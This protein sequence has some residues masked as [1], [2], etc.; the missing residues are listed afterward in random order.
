MESPPPLE[1]E[2]RCRLSII[3]K[4]RCWRLRTE[5]LCWTAKEYSD[6]TALSEVAEIR[7]QYAPTRFVEHMFRCRIR[8]RNGK[9][10]HLQ[11]H[12]FAGVANFEDRSAAYRVRFFGSLAI[13]H[14]A[15]IPKTSLRNCCRVNRRR[16]GSVCLFSFAP[17][18]RLLHP[19]IF[20]RAC[21]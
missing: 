13:N 12:H 6:Q 4:E 1:L 7:L 8:L 11:N 17:H 21:Q 19:R 20:L 16:A 18:R 14:V 3:E 9:V 5:E 15:L 10:W 2:Y